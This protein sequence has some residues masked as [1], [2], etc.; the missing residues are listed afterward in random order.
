MKKLLTLFMCIALVG[1]YSCSNDDDNDNNGGGGNSAITIKARVLYSTDANGVDTKPD[2]GAKVYVFYD[3]DFNNANG[4]TYQV[5]GKYVNDGKTITADQMAT[6]GSDGN[7]V[8]EQKFSSRKITVVVDSKHYEG[9]YA[10]KYYP[11]FNENIILSNIFK[12]K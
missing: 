11:S 8:I 6:I 7:A 3:L 1:L 12:A 5:G 4:Y 10:E 9:Q 2:A